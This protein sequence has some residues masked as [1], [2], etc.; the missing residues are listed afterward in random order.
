MITNQPTNQTNKQTGKQTN[1]Q[2]NKQTCIFIVVIQDNE[3]R[4][5]KFAALSVK[6]LKTVKCMYIITYR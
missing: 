5:M 1:N 2:A 4:L 3:K 6:T